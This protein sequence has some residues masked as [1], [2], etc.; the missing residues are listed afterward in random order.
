MTDPAEV[1][2]RLNIAFKKLLHQS[3]DG[4]FEPHICSVCDSLLICD[5]LNIL[6]FDSLK[7]MSHLVSFD[8]ELNERKPEKRTR[9]VQIM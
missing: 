5:S 2:H 4:G 9:Y 3:E 7:Q 1:T 6:S 8:N